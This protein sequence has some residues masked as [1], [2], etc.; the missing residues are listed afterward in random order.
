MKKVIFRILCVVLAL[1]MS[2][3]LMACADDAPDSEKEPL[4][5]ESTTPD[6]EEDV[7]EFDPYDIADSL[8]ETSFGGREF[9]ILYCNDTTLNYFYSHAKSGDLIG[10]A[11]WSAIARTEERFDVD[12]AAMKTA[13]DDEYVYTSNLATQINSGSTDF[14][15]ANVHDVL[16]GNLSIQGYFLN[17]LDFD[18]FD[19]SKPW[20]SEKAIKSL[21]F[22]DQLYLLSSSLS[23]YGLGSTQV[24]FFNKQMMDDRG[25][26]YPY[27]D[28]LDMNWYLDDMFASIEDVYVD[29]NGNGKDNED[30]YG[31]ML[32]RE[33][34]AVYE[35]FGINLL[36][37]SDD[38]MELILNANDERAYDLIEKLY[39]ILYEYDGGYCTLRA[40]MLDMFERNQGI[41]LTAYLRYAIENFRDADCTYGIV[42]YPMLDDQQ[43][44]YHAGYVERFT[45]IPTTSKDTD[46]V[47]TILESMSAEGY[48][49]V[50]PAYY[51]TAL[52]GRHTHDSESVQMLELIRESRVIDFA[53]I[54][55][56]NTACC[57]ALSELLSQKSKNYASY[58]AGKESAAKVRIEELTAFFEKMAD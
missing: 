42:P 38:G 55:S 17:I 58:Y 29:V 26:E 14:E 43:S 7:E 32:P 15:V 50:T 34:Y 1:M 57:R 35:T 39:E 16:G 33:F 45:V 21:S 18:Q 48:R 46:F 6:P 53:Y 8:P 51:E 40:D 41:Y 12:I 4:P 19:F 37:K 11:V 2:I 31:L 20:W 9:N 23:Y 5:S 13:T 56:N 36:E 30:I 10:D 49:Q 28:V 27:E 22:M 24:V 25:I 52:K 44:G 3:P 47:G 54:Y